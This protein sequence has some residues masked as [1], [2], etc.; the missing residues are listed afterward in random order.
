MPGT[1][2]ET[3]MQSPAT[4]LTRSSVRA[5]LRGRAVGAADTLNFRHSD[6][7]SSIRLPQRQLMARR[8][9]CLEAAIIKTACVECGSRAVVIGGELTSGAFARCGECESPRG[10]YA[11]FRPGDQGSRDVCGLP[12]GDQGGAQRKLWRV[13]Q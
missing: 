7:S 12:P 11:D 13:L 9:S 3:A 8:R 10:M 2:G 1:H 6:R 4:R 5:L